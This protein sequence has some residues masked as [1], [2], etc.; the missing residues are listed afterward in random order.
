M[1]LLLVALASG[2]SPKEI[3][4][5]YKSRSGRIAYFDDLPNVLVIGKSSQISFNDGYSWSPVKEFSDQEM[6]DVIFDPSDRLRAFAYSTDKVF[7]TTDL[8]GH[9][10]SV[11]LDLD[12]KIPFG[13]VEVNF[14]AEDPKLLLVH[15]LS[16]SFSC[17]ANYFVS[18]DGL[19]TAPKKLPE[20]LDS[21]VFAK[22]LKTF[23][24]GGR[25]EAIVCSVNEVNLYKHSVKSELVIS[26]NFFET[27]TTI[28][29]DAL[30]LGQIIDVRV[31]ELF[32]VITAKVDRYNQDLEVLLI[33][34]KDTKVFEKL[35]LDVEL[36]RGAVRFLKPSVLSLFLEI[37]NLGDGVPKSSI[38]ASDST[39]LRFRRVAENTVFDTA[40]SQAGVDGVWIVLEFKDNSLIEDGSSMGKMASKVSIDDGRTWLALEVVDDSSCRLADGCSLHVAPFSTIQS[41]SR[42]KKGRSVN[43]LVALGTT[44]Q[45]LDPEEVQLKTYVSRDGGK[46]WRKALDVPIM[47][48]FGD[49]GNL[50][51]GAELTNDERNTIYYS[52]DQG[53]TWKMHE[54]LQKGSPEE[55]ISTVDGSGTKFVYVSSNSKGLNLHV[56]DFTKAFDGKVCGKSDYEKV[57]ARVHNG[58]PVCVYGRRESFNRRKADAK[59]FRAK[60]YEDVQIQQEPCTCTA[61]D[62]E[63]SF[64]FKPEGGRCVPDYGRIK[65]MCALGKK[66]VLLKDMQLVDGSSCTGG[67]NLIKEVEVECAKADETSLVQSHLSK[68]EGNLINYVYAKTLANFTD[69][70]FVRVS[71]GTVHASNNGGLL[72]VRFPVDERIAKMLYSPVGEH[73]VMLT[74]LDSFYSSYNGGNTFIR[75]TAPGDP[76]RIDNMV[77]GVAAFHDSNPERFL[78]INSRDELHETLDGGR[79][80]RSLTDGVTNCDYLADEIVC[81]ARSGSRYELIKLGH[82]GRRTLFNNIVD[83]ALR[84]QFLVVAT[85]DESIEELRAKVLIDGETFADAHYPNDFQVKRET[86]YTFLDT[87]TGSIFF[88]VMTNGEKHR[89]AGALLKSNSNGT[90]FVLSLENVNRNEQGY[91]DFDRIESLEGVLIAN[92]IDNPGAPEA[93]ALKLMISFNDGAQ[94][95]YL[96]PPVRDSAGKKFCAG[97]LK[98]CSLNLKGYTE[99]PDYRDT[100]ESA[101]AIGLLIGVGS[102]GP[103]LDRNNL[104]TFMLLDGG[105]SWKEIRKGLYMWEYGDHGTILVLVNVD[106]ATD[107]L[108]YLT[109]MGESWKVFKFSDSPVRVDDLATIPLDMARKFVIYA[110]EGHRTLMFGI[111]F[112]HYFPRQCQLN[113]DNIGA[114]DYEYW[115]PSD[116][117]LREKC[118]FGHQTEY[119]RPKAASNCFIGLTPLHLGSKLTKNCTCTRVDYECDYNYYRDLDGTCKLVKGLTPADRMREM[120]TKPD[121]FQYFEPTGY[122]RLPK[123]TCVGGKN[124]D[125]WKARPCPGREEEFKERLGR[126]LGFWRLLFLILVPV[127]LACA[128]G[129]F[130]YDRGIR[131]NGGFARLGQIR[132][133]D[134]DFSPI[135]DNNV[136][137]AVNTVVRGLVA[138]VAASVALFKTVRRVDRAMLDKV[139][140]AVFGRNVG[141]RNYVRV[142]DE[143]DELFGDFEENYD[144]DNEMHFEVTDEPPEFH[145]YAEPPAELFGIDDADEASERDSQVGT[146]DVGQELDL[147]SEQEPTTEAPHD[148]DD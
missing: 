126:K 105:V 91:V 61:N 71:D 72:F 41:E 76:S 20:S 14:N 122:R 28:L 17:K 147:E 145:D 54:L 26:E 49:A 8:G 95:L 120:C 47:Y 13:G 39:G 141:R 116:P 94:W 77:Q 132:L 84:D 11:K 88:H 42:A 9:W 81:R 98:S 27:K 125:S 100:Y 10:T 62:Y 123:T 48:A 97:D 63:C 90:Y 68:V 128:T 22:G 67:P 31:L 79:L 33:V 104:A 99:R 3:T 110:S 18:K 43:I 136:D 78:W 57:Y 35:N 69:N 80:F 129:W 56:L 138:V 36:Q 5:E 133:D 89:E 117:A 96:V 119:L 85:I 12:G 92:V 139:S 86:A 58:E 75:R 135:E 53:L 111:D 70:L 146:A 45:F 29:S 6:L 87:L 112:T 34:T 50:I 83:Y 131:R 30:D 65:P 130:V 109:D 143:E 102:V 124:F 127:A 107:E 46:T 25:K 52:L 24:Y 60:L 40:F 16:C 103:S 66:S 82:G 140:L 38:Y 59:C 115:L 106:Q 55:L 113:L 21:C 2:F 118:L 144:D 121:V 1:L 23:N 19:K 64:K 114:G 32:M 134:D 108:L 37:A 15:T 7:V 51:V 4:T 93:K 101:S 73:L 44:G 142:P 74:E 148:S 137:V